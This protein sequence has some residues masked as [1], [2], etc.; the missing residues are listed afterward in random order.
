LAQRNGR[1]GRSAGPSRWGSIQQAIASG[2]LELLG[3]ETVNGLDTLHLRLFGPDRS[4]RVDI[5][6]DSA[7]Y[8]PVRDIAGKSSGN[9]GPDEFPAEIAVTT[10][11]WL[12]RTDENL[13]R[14]VL[15][16]PAGFVQM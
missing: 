13:A 12:P 5:W 16:P 9:A 14:L 4:Y 2:T 10:Y 11:S 3:H 1:S 6:V 15:T 7:T 8:L